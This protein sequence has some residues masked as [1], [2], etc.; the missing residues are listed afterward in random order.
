MRKQRLVDCRPRWVD[1]NRGV[2]C[3]LHFDCPENHEGCEHTIPFVPALDGS[4]P[5]FPHAHWERTGEDFETL[6]LTPSIKRRPVHANREEAI[7]AGCLPEYVEDWM[8]CAMHVNLVD[9]TFHFS[10]DSR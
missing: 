4:I 9:G 5:T 1:D 10:G 2:T 3:Y 8:Y 6:T 7:A